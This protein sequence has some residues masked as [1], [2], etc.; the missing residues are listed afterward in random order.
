MTPPS[1]DASDRDFLAWIHERLE[2][3]YGD[4]RLIGHMHRLRSIIAATPA[5]QHT[6][7]TGEGKNSLE[8]LMDSL[9]P[10]P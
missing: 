3:V 6:R 1:P 10:T 9:P 8:A 5:G 4:S 7:V 2:H